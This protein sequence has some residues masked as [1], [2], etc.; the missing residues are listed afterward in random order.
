M[1]DEEKKAALDV[2][3]LIVTT[4]KVQLTEYRMILRVSCKS[5]AL[6][7]MSLIAFSVN[8]AQPTPTTSE[9]RV[10]MLGTGSPVADPTRSGPAVAI[11]VNGR[12]YLVD[13]GPGIVRRSAQGAKNFPAL[14]F[15]REC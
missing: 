9:A 14:D 8:Q 6:V 1:S 12:S 2:S 5:C 3:V 13:A 4:K 11:V 7:L 10:V 15:H